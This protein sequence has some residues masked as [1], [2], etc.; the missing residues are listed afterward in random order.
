MSWR[1]RG[2]KKIVG[3]PSLAACCLAREMHKH[4]GGLIHEISGL[5]MRASIL[6][7]AMEPCAHV[8]CLERVI[9]LLIL[10]GV[11]AFP[12]PHLARHADG[13]HGAESSERLGQLLLAGIAHPG[14][15][16]ARRNE[17]HEMRGELYNDYA[18]CSTRCCSQ[19]RHSAAYGPDPVSNLRP[20]N[21][22][23]ERG[24]TVFSGRMGSSDFRRACACP[25]LR[26]GSMRCS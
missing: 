16:K 8:V 17:G 22:S 19:E 26:R 21:P 13:V 9:C 5:G 18:H 11:L 6:H 24:D 14:G 7:Q 23:C 20:E 4:G 12:H 15:Q 25:S 10:V 3:A 2:E 1:V